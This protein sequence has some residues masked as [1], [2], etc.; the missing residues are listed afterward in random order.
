[1]IRHNAPVLLMIAPLIGAGICLLE[2]AFPR[3]RAC[4]AASVISLLVSLALLIPFYPGQ[5]PQPA[6]SVVGGW[7]AFV[8]IQQV[9][10][11]FAWL[12]CAVIFALSLLI[13]LFAFAE[14]AYDPTFYFLLLISVAGMVG[15]MLAADLFN[16]F[17]CLEISGLASYIL[18]AYAQKGDAVFASFQYLL[19]SSLGMVFLL[20][21]ILIFYQHTGTL[22]LFD[23][24]AYC[25]AHTELAP[26]FAVGVAA[27]IVGIGMRAAFVPFH[28]WLPDAHANAP[29]PVSALLSGV[30]IK[31]GF[32]AVWRIVSAFE[33]PSFQPIFLYLGAITALFGAVFALAQ[34]DCKK[35]LAWS[36]IS[37]MGY[38]VASFGVGTPFG[39]TASYAHL[40]HHAAFKSLLFLCIGGVI[41][42]TGERSL[43]RLGGLAPA[44]PLLTVAFAVGAGSIAG[45]PPFNG[46]VSKKLIGYGL[47][48]A[49]VA[50]LLISLAGIGTIASF[51]KLSAIFRPNHHADTPT[52]LTRSLPQLAYLP[53]LALSAF[54]LLSGMFGG[55]WLNVISRLL[56]GV[57]VADNFHAYTLSGLL[58]AA[59]TVLLGA[60]LYRGVISRRGQTISAALRRFHPGLNVALLLLIWGFLL[61]SGVVFL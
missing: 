25:A 27:L 45:I 8:G 19:L 15:V 20:L 13:L 31:I 37:Q 39:L 35:L 23:T 21:G 51:L 59:A 24:A 50:S 41:H 48:H 12:T 43:K 30:V 49:P 56:F 28:T 40:V 9:F 29:H 61:F 1:M 26:T 38:I 53:P 22:S 16:L 17:V 14:N 60:A 32:L 7:E 3:V 42:V 4:K 2:K 11:G 33:M 6:V 36:S 46:F 54:C 18:I 34:T 55:V 5:T 52:P 57:R 58:S 44:L 10:D 47:E